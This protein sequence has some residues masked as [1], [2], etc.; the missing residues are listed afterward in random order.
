MVPE[1]LTAARVA[2]LPSP[3]VSG[4]GAAPAQDVQSGSLTR[5]V[6]HDVARCFPAGIVRHQRPSPSAGRDTGSPCG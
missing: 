1:R 2:T 5:N 6:R 3:G 4:I